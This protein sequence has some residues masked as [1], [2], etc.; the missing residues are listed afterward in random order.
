MAENVNGE[1]IR[2]TV[3]VKNKKAAIE[4]AKHLGYTLK[5]EFSEGGWHLVGSN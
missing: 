3:V 2:L 5:S 4:K 1:L